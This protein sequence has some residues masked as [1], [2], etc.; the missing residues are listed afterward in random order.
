MRWLSINLLKETNEVDVL[1]KSFADHNPL[2]IEL[3]TKYK[4]FIW[5]LNT[6]DLQDKKFKGNTKKQLKEFFKNNINS[7][8]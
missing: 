1:P 8:K 7:V 2:L 3:E 5:R 6:I 4:T